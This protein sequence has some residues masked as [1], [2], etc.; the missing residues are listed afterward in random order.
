MSQGSSPDR[1]PDVSVIIPTV[2]QAAHLSACLTALQH[3][4]AGSPTHVEV[5][6]V[7][8]G[9]DPAVRDVARAAPGIIVVESP[10]NRGFGGG[11]TLGVEA[12]TA[13][14]LAFLNDD[15]RVTRGWLTPLL[16]TLAE[17][18]RVAAVGPRVL[19]GD[20]LVQEIG[21]IIW[22]DGTT[23]PFAR[24]AA[25]TSTTW[26]WRRRVDYCSACALVV[27]RVAWDAVGGFDEGFHPAYYE[28]VDF[29]LRLEAAGYEVWVDPRADVVHAESASSTSAFKQFLFARHHARLVERRSAELAARLAPPATSALLTAAEVA[30]A[31]RLAPN[32]PRV[33]V[34]DDRVPRHGLG[35]GFDR[36]ADALLALAARGARVRLLPTEVPAGFDP[37]LA[38][39]GVAV[40]DE[41]HEVVL[42][43]ELRACD[44]AIAS[45]P[46]NARRLHAACARLAVA[47][48]PRI[49]YDAEAL[50]HRRLERQARL[51]AGPEAAVLGAQA[52]EWLACEAAIAAE[53]DAVV[54]VSRDEAAFFTGAGA[55]D[56]RVA[57]PWLRNASPT[58]GSLAGRADIGL[59]AGWLAGASSP[60]GDALEWFAAE[61]LPR[62]VA[63]VPWARLRVTGTL[64]PELRHLEGL[65]V[66]AEGFVPDLHV[67]YRRLRVAVAPL[68]FGAGVKLKTVEAL[69]FGVPV[70]ATSVGAEGLDAMPG[71]VVAVHDEPAAFADAVI[72]RLTDVRTWRAHRAAIDAA[73][74]ARPHVD[75]A[76]LVMGADGEGPRVGRS[77]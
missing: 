61:V 62:V 36:M 47:D 34:L 12:A 45:R 20:G 28:D 38:K 17:H 69:Q 19:G 2:S 43:E 71:D 41:A 15:V 59:V 23:R 72:A 74:Q 73:L 32:G 37:V 52:A 8:N 60:N 68:R 29:C 27:R 22:R 53:A 44:A 58:E 39:A 66:R 42:D 50:Y 7:L 14:V 49:V 10:V 24:G 55:R 9:A 77:L 6:V 11:C 35:S 65:H 26:R 70:V 1:A 30:A 57:T 46:N 64:P 21:S 4:Q 76:T 56:V 18:P 63:A 48:R 75:W 3:A 40:I 16:E 51:S 54:C 13:P 33:L 31:D 67:F 5:V 25:A